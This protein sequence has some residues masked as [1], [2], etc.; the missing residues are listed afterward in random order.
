[1]SVLRTKMVRTV[2][3][4]P[5]IV[6][7]DVGTTGNMGYYTTVD[8]ENRF[9]LSRFHPKRAALRYSKEVGSHTKARWPKP[10]ANGTPVCWMK[11]GMN[12]EILPCSCLT[13]KGHRHTYGECIIAASSLNLRNYSPV[14]L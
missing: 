4:G 9:S 10:Y 1:M 6:T 13:P 5:L 3:E 2:K 8:G 14:S 7:V 12:Q 11:N